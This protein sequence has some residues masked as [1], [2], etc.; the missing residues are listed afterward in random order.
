M[1]RLLLL[2]LLTAGIVGALAV[3]S[4]D[5]LG[6][7]R[8]VQRMQMYTAMY[9]WH[10]SHYHA[11]WGMPVVQVVPPTATRQA[12]W[13]W[14]VGNSR[15]TTIWHQYWRNYPGAGVYNGKMFSPTPYWPSDTDQFGVYHVRGPW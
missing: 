1:K 4:A 15:T 2:A 12:H 9:P 13:G 8:R 3:D 5:A 14:G 10:G 6:N 7:R 11:A